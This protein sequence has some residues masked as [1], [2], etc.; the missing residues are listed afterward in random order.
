MTTLVSSKAPAALLTRLAERAT[1]AGTP[2]EA[3]AAGGVEVER[4]VAEGEAIDVVVLAAG[5]IRR[6]AEEGH[7]VGEP[8]TILVTDAVAAV[9]S[10]EPV[11]DLTSADSLRAAVESVRAVG[12]STGPSGDAV[13][14]LLESWGLADRAVVAR[15]GVPVGR[16]LVDGEVDLAFQQRTELDAME[17][18]HVVGPLP[19]PL[20]LTTAFVGAVTAVAAD[21]DAARAA[22]DLLAD[23][24][25]APDQPAKE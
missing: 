6:L 14:R 7:V 25:G 19:E 2:V 17:G 1:A 5:A 10:G 13:T 16:L 18:V 8:R 9:R 21:P 15:P 22:L 23:L 3:Q 11:P 24:A 4:R 20:A 12:V